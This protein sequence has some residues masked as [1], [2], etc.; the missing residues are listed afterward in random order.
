MRTIQAHA[1]SFILGAVFCL[2]L[3]KSCEKTEIETVIP[4]VKNTFEAVNPVEV[5]HD[6]TYVDKWYTKDSII[7][8]ELRNPVNDSLS[9]AYKQAKDSIERYKQFLKAIQIK[10]YSQEFD[11]SLLLVKVYGNVQGDIKEMSLDYTLKQRT[12]KIQTPEAVF[13]W[14]LGGQIRTDLNRINP[15]YD[16]TSG[17]Q[18][19]KGNIFRVGY[20]RMSGTEYFLV[21]FEFSLYTLKK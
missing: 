18:N 17:L 1:V 12:I 8:V 15:S 19:K 20:S 3:F 10:K 16:I 11:D 13:R 4:E 2:L 21:G 6:T 14:T 5:D 9:S 7:T